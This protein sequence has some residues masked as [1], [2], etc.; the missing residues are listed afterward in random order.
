MNVNEAYDLT[1]EVIQELEYSGIKVKRITS[2]SKDDL[3]VILKYRSSDRISP[4]KWLHVTFYFDTEEQR[5]AIH[6]KARELGWRGI[7]FDTGGS[8][9]F[10]DWEID[11]SF[12]VED[13]P[14]GNLEASRDVVEDLIVEN[15]EEGLNPDAA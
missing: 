7:G 11:W 12:R 13:T 5:L 8:S 9:G 10:R 6:K 14:D 15:M 3:E 2:K 4:D 1:I